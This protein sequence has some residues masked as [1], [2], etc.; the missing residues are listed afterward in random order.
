MAS[1]EALKQALVNADKAGDTDAARKLAA[2]IKRYETEAS[3]A[4][5]TIN[6]AFGDQP[7]VAGTTTAPAEP[8]VVDKAIGAGE[9]GLSL[10]TG[11]AGGAAGMIGGTASQL[12]KSI[13]DGTYGTADAADLVERAAAS[14]AQALT[15]EPRTPAGKEYAQAA[16]ET[17]APLAALGPMAAPASAEAQLLSSGIRQ[18]ATTTAPAISRAQGVVGGLANRTGETISGVATRAAESIGLREGA[19]ERPAQGDLSSARTPADTLRSAK[20][21]GLPTPIEL[22]LGA[23]TRDPAQLAFEKE[24]MKNPQMGGPLRQRAEE[25]NIQALQ[26]FEG[27]LDQTGAVAPDMAATGNAVVDALSKGYTAA[28]NK[29]NVAYRKA[30]SSEEAN[31]EVDTNT[32]VSLGEGE[33]AINNSLIGY[34]NGKVTGVPS[35]AV[36]DTA[37]KLAVKLG[38]AAEDA[39]GTLVGRP[40]TVGAMEEFRKE[41]SGTAKW[42]D[43]VGIRE[44]TIIK[45]LIDAQT[46]PAAGPLFKAA[47]TE[48]A[49]MAR[50]YENRAVVAR[51]LQ[52]VKGKDDPK[53]A[54]D[55]VFQKSVMTSSPDEI[56]FLKRVL[57]TSGKSGQKAWREVQ[58]ALVR[59]IRDESTKG[60]GMDASDNPLV[61]P[62]K[63]NQVVQTLDKN[64]RLDIVLGK[65]RAQVVRD[66]NDVVK[67]V[68]TVPPGTLVNN[69]G[70]AGVLMA[71]IAEAGATGALTGLPVPIVSGLKALKT[72]IKDKKLKV[73][74]DRALNRHSPQQ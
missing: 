10:A 9:A 58:G 22:T 62:A 6:Q 16:A 44:E 24:M 50:K 73:K 29:V 36:P 2:V 71:A 26:N 35:S 54:A 11:M 69:S 43:R 3:G 5:T 13:L 19:P 60:L 8:T 21:E 30:R 45:K 51:L 28:K 37:R 53:V 4:E 56:T 52:N 66:L 41:L 63:L 12:A 15:Y 49:A 46:D 68:N 34:L 65:Q 72:H 64:D 42:D 27:V 1:L 17:L 40:T 33:N 57:Q 47:R 7:E 23:E 70:T 39:E 59:H 32:V 48:R 38:L 14:G 61:S 18:A 67:Y 31:A 74:I 20:A 25:N 55:Q